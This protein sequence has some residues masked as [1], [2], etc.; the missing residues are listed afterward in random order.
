VLGTRCGDRFF[1]FLVNLIILS[2][3]HV[4]RVKRQNLHRESCL[5]LLTPLPMPGLTRG[6]WCSI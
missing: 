4:N 3:H 1:A 2:I 5:M 6:I